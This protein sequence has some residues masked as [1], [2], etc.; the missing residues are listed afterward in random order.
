MD[1]CFIALAGIVM[2]MLDGKDFRLSEVLGRRNPEPEP[3]ALFLRTK[4]EFITRVRMAPTESS[5]ADDASLG[6]GFDETGLLTNSIF[7][8]T[9]GIEPMTKFLLLFA[10]S[11]LQS[12]PSNSRETFLDKLFTGFA[13]SLGVGDTIFKSVSGLFAAGA[14]VGSI[15]ISVPGTVGERTSP[16]TAERSGALWDCFFELS[17]AC[18]ILVLLVDPLRKLKLFVIAPPIWTTFKIIRNNNH[19]KKRIFTINI[20]ST[21]IM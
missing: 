16:N 4:L 11:L 19:H 17:S 7:A 18:F 14:S 15:F 13:V 6:N 12:T 8:R 20:N 3:L 21:K 10:A 1:T 2:D 9:F 5:S